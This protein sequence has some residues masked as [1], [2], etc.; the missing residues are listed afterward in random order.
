MQ[1]RIKNII[2]LRSNCMYQLQTKQWCSLTAKRQI[3]QGNS[4][5]IDTE[6]CTKCVL[7]CPATKNHSVRCVVTVALIVSEK[8][9][10][11]CCFSLP[12]IL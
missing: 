2:K 8:K 11:Q 9:N 12:L 6:S 3:I 10:R 4:K 7:K 1:S 5:T